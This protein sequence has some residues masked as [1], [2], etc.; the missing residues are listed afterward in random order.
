M[1]TQRIGLGEWLPDQPGVIGGIT[2]AKNCYPT[3]TGYASFPSEADFSAAA[4]EDLTSLVYAKDQSGTSKFFAAG[5][6]KIYEVSSVGA[7]T[8]VWYTAATYAQ[9]GSTTLTV[10][11]TA[12]GWKTGDSAYLNFTSGTAV[13]GQFTITKLTADTFTITT[14]S[15]TTSGNVRISSTELGYNTLTG[16]IFRFTKF[17]NRIIGTNFTERLQ[18]YVADASSSFKNLSDDAPVAKFITVVRDFVVCAHIDSSGTPRPY[19][20]QW[21]GI[22]DETT[23]TTSQITQADFQDIPDGGHITGIRGGE[24]GLVLMEKAIH[25][26]VYVGTPFVFQFDNISRGKGCIAPGSV[27]Q[28]EGLTFFLSDD[29][30][31]MC[32]GQQVMPIGAEKVDRFFFNDADLDFSTMSSAADPI[33]KLVMWNY[34]DKFANRKLIVYSITTKKWSYMDATADYISD[35]STASVTLEQ[36]DSINSSIDAL[37]VT[38]DSALYFGGKFFLGGTDGTK[39]ITFNGASK[40]AVIETGDISTNTMSLVTLARPQIDNGSATVA[41]ASR[42]LL[43]EGVT[44]GSDVTADSDNR[45]SLRG[46]GRYHRLRVK[47]TGDNWSMA[48]A[49]DADINQMGN[50]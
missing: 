36:L 25:R 1:A 22:N 31:Y 11:A 3:S 48:V 9:T 30:F 32:D 42:A 27:C 37:A 39:V 47:P 7:L 13:D 34:K 8:D 40:S 4:A 20:L 41:I 35:A 29:G 45:V 18:S 26:M 14:T 2:L 6:R 49:V 16:N 24:F 23:W 33:R 15:A 10:T 21:S 5:K 19:R 28:Y 12:H 46:S 17:G 38:L 43:N 50:R 44:F